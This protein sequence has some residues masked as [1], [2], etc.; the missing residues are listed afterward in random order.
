MTILSY[1]GLAEHEVLFVLFHCARSSNGIA[2]L[3][4]RVLDQ[5]SGPLTLEEAKVHTD[6]LQALINETHEKHGGLL[7]PMRFDYVRGRAIKVYLHTD[8]KILDFADLYD[9]DT[10]N[11]YCAKVI[12]FA[13]RMKRDGLALDARVDDI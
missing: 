13:Q 2:H 10:L 1:E 6:G 8:I 3:T 11:G 4:E 12:A 9:R 7:L 5:L